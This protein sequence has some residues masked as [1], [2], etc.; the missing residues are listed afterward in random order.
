MLMYSVKLTIWALS[1]IPF[2]F[3]YLDNIPNNKDQLRAQAE[4]SAK[5]NSHLVETISGIETVKAQGME[6]ISEWKWEKLY[7]RQIKSGFRNTLT[8]TTIFNKQLFTTII[9]SYSYLGW[10]KHGS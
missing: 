8:S 10:G 7:S 5:V 3:I 6:M 4:A 9:W 1:V 2:F